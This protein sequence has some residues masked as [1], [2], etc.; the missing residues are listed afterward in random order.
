M[1]RVLPHLLA[2]AEASLDHSDR[3]MLHRLYQ[4]LGEYMEPPAALPYSAQHLCPLPLSCQQSRRAK[5][6]SSAPKPL[7]TDLK[8]TAVEMSHF[9]P[10]GSPHPVASP[11]PLPPRSLSPLSPTFPAS[12]TGSER[13]KG[14]LARP[15]ARNS[16]MVAKRISRRE[17]LAR[18]P[19]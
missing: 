7:V 19:G 14:F 8:A 10:M 6:P 9:L 12:L 18:S 4:R 16:V 2:P 15:N 3:A 17:S 1:T 5:S 13:P 11:L